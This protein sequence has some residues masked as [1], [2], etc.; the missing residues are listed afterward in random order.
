MATEMESIEIKIE[1]SSS[2]AAESVQS[3]TSALGNLKSQLS[4]MKGLGGVFNGIVN[5]VNNT[6]R[7]VLKELGAGMK[8]LHDQLKKLDF[9]NL[10]DLG[11]AM[12]N[13]AK[14][15]DLDNLLGL[16]IALT[17]ISRLDFS[18]LHDLTDAM[19][20]LGQ[21]AGGAD[22]SGIAE[23]LA[24]IRDMMAGG[25]GGD[26][27]ST[28]NA[29]RAFDGLGISLRGLLAPLNLLQKGFTKLWGTMF[30]IGGAALTKPFRDLGN[31]VKS[32]VSKVS[33]LG[34]SF[35]RILMYRAI[36]TIIK[37]IGDAFREGTNNVYQ[38]SKALGGEF[39]ANMDSAASSMQY[40]KNSIGAA[41]APLLNALIPALNAVI[42]KIVEAIN[43]INQLFAR[44]SGASYWTRAKK[45][46]TEY[47]AAAGG[48]GSAAKEALKYLAPFDE[49]NVLPDNNSGGGG[50]GGGGA[51][52]G[53]MFE[54][55]DFDND[56]FGQ[57]KD[58]FENGEWRELGN[59]LGMK[60]NEIFDSIPWA[61]IG[62][63][64]GYAV[65]GVIETLYS[66]IKTIHFEDIGSY[67]ATAFNNAL[68]EINFDTWG[69]L[70][71][72]KFTAAIDFLIGFIEGLDPALVGKSIGDFFNGTISEAQEWLSNKPWEEIGGKIGTLIDETI[73]NLYA[74]LSTK[75]F[76]GLG[77]AIA[78]LINGALA[79]IDF[80]KAG[81]TL[82][83][84]FEAVFDNLLAFIGGLNWGEIGQKIGQFI[85]GAFAELGTWLQGIDWIS[86]AVNL[87][88]GFNKMILEIDWA[89]VGQTLSDAVMGFFDFA[90][91]AL[92]TINW[93]ALGEAVGDFITSVN[94]L[95]VIG[96]LAE[97]GAQLVAG[98]L[99]GMLSA[100]GKIGSW[101]KEHIV[102][103]FVNWLRKL[104]DIN[105]PS[106]VMAKIGGYVAQGL[107][108][109]ILAPFKKIGQWVSKN[110]LT[111]LKNALGNGKEAIVDF[112]VGVA[113]TAAEWWSDVQRWWGQKVGKVKEFTTG[114]ANKASEWWSNV[115]K[116]WRSTTV[117]KKVDEFNT[118]VANKA[119]EWWSNV[120]NWWHNTALGKTVDE[121]VTNV[122][123]NSA[124]WWGNVKNW[125]QG[126]SKSGVNFD[127]KVTDNSSANFNTVKIGFEKQAK[128]N[129]IKVSANISAAANV[130][131]TLADSVTKAWNNNRPTLTT[132]IN[133]TSIKMPDFLIGAKN[134]Q[135]T[136]QKLG[137]HTTIS[138]YA[139]G[140]FPDAGQLFMAREAGPE[141]VGSIGNRSAVANNDQIVEA[142][143]RGVYQAVR[144]A[145][146]DG[147]N[148]NGDERAVN[149]Y[150]DGKEI[151]T[152]T[153]RYQRQFARAGAV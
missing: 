43:W 89:Q 125:W 110:I 107:L 79:D 82:A 143:S 73:Q 71:V 70:L 3:L 14:A 33:Q 23:T 42:D 115:Q 130:G 27:S 150:L 90:Q 134:G 59:L 28:E 45:Q 95:G 145:M 123:D 35:K 116:W 69:R 13:M 102:D 58:A 16:G 5:A 113:N 131:K 142:V 75:K 57:L 137:T 140:G 22:M 120:K 98:L 139:Q 38:W 41:V 151:A 77:A 12:K 32:A 91:A 44:L 2:K 61:E 31:S 40:F 80:G 24:E 147:G 65:N 111:P 104:F 39:A 46:A 88:T 122:K 87:T 56:F 99:Q 81:R 66:F 37:E 34:S 119:T 1:A 6:D 64:I 52:Y 128:N 144:E 47:A 21:S 55:V 105:S 30:K 135:V 48:A 103:P 133:V 62:Q 19:Q 84:A 26:T 149:I 18:N 7:S 68:A 36:R 141:L 97:I 132:K 118:A 67:L 20:A 17:G 138:A 54:N 121:F 108:N 60:V 96:K 49:L 148:G 9:S 152:T 8:S 109:G 114:V 101:L 74:V 63:K 92:A 83:L 126:V 136:Y 106:R 146:M 4:G 72:A 94:W 127:A 76:G 153:T 10:N 85:N 50:G 129:P 15:S 117:G 29:S 78:D 53:D 112:V 11:N 100:F 86:L 51:D 25:A 93:Q 124:S